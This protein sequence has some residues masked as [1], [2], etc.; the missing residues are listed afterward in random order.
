MLSYSFA[1]G[2]CR[3]WDRQ[4]M[5]GIIPGSRP[6]PEMDFRDRTPVSLVEQMFSPLWRS[7][8]LER[9]RS[10]AEEELQL[11]AWRR[12]PGVSPAMP[13][14]SQDINPTLHSVFVEHLL[15][16]R[17]GDLY[18]VLEIDKLRSWSQRTADS[19]REW[20]KWRT[21]LRWEQKLGGEGKKVKIA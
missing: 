7:G 19:G 11:R 14:L 17:H 2:P 16:A 5:P 12:N 8:E 9:I 13:H 21:K 20:P 4:L 10:P 15:F 18:Q 1:G 6:Q 3:T